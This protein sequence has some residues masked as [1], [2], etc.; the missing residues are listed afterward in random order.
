[1]L[2]LYTSWL[3]V[4]EYG[5]TDIISVYSSLLFGVVSG[6]IADAIFVIPK[7]VDKN[8]K[9]K[10]FTS[11]ICYLMI[12]SVITFCVFLILRQIFNYYNVINT[13]SDNMFYI[14]AILLSSVIFA[15]IQQFTRAIDKILVYSFSGVVVTITTFLYSFLLIPNYGVKGFVVVT[16]LSNVSG[17]IFNVLVTSLYQYFNFSDFKLEKL[18]ELLTYSLPLVPN[19]IMWWLVN[20]SNRPLL[21]TYCDLTAIGILAVASKFPGFLNI[22][23]TA[24]NSSWVISVLEEYK[25]ENFTEFFNKGLHL[26]AFMLTMVALFICAISDIVIDIFTS[27]TDY[28]SAWKFIPLLALSTIFSCMAGLVGT[29]FSAVRKSMY[30]FYSSIW[31]AITAVI[32]N[33]VLIST[34]GLWGAVI[35]SCLSMFV[36]LLSRILYSRKYVQ[37]ECI[38]PYIIDISFF[39]CVFCV[40][41]LIDDVVVSYTLIA[42]LLFM[43]ILF[44]KKLFVTFYGVIQNKIVKKMQ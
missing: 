40:K 18:K 9:K 11:G 27:G 5:T 8:T 34:I 16:I 44:N 25:K 1:M 15:Y 38:T 17:I 12:A 36:M 13:F 20:A 29:V 22:F 19:S 43:F 28:L 37:Y 21:E 35:S 39:L 23:L 33:Y 10:Y 24:F 3:S 31:A 2:P 30:Y 7:G 32:L 6:C 4:E 14:Y 26:F 41:L 42:F